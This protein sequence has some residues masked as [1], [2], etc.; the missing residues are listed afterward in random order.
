MGAYLCWL[1]VRLIEVHRVLREDGSLYLH[2]DHTASAWSKTLLDAVFGPNKMRREIIWVSSAV[3]GFKSLAQNFVRGHDTIHYYARGSRP[4]FNKSYL[5]YNERQLKRFSGIDDEGRR[6]KSITKSRRL[7]LDESKGMPISSVWSD[8]ANFQTV[9][10]HREKVGYPTQ[11]PLALL[12]RIIKASS[13]EGDVVLDPF[14][15]SGT[16]LVAAERLGRR[17]R[18]IDISADAVRLAAERLASE[19]LRVCPP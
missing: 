15:G 16:A 18:G 5:P 10:N 11:K 8:I 4:K 14:C 1:G 12:E 9:V 6:Y 7:Y 19:R 3:S 2:T 17:W 13:N